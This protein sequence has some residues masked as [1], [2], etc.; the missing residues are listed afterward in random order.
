MRRRK[1][2]SPFRTVFLWTICLSLIGWGLWQAELLRRSV[3]SSSPP[4]ATSQPD[5]AIDSASIQR[6]PAPG[7]TPPEL[8]EAA[9]TDHAPT[10]TTQELAVEP[11]H[12]EP[13][14]IFD[15]GLSASDLYAQGHAAL[16]AGQTL[17]GRF[18]LNE[19]LA[20]T[21]DDAQAAELRQTLSALNLPIFLGSDLLPDDPAA[22]LVEIQDGDNFL[23]IARA[24]G[25]NAAFLQTLNPTLS[26]ANLKPGTG[27][28]IVQGPFQAR[29][30]KHADRLDLYARDLYVAS[31]AVDFPEG[32]DLP[33]GDYLIAPGTKLLLGPPAA[34]RIWLGFQGL[35]PATQSVT[36]GWIFGT[37]GPRG[38]DPRNR[39]TG[40]HL[41]TPDLLQLYN[42]LTEGRSHLHVDP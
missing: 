29:I 26:P 39:S 22:R 33:R 11:A 5:A 23:T 24:Y 20:R 40:I 38:T 42:T 3:I 12:L 17:A 31:C 1:R 14:P 41:A 30:S 6:P 9:A 27:I 7:D 4:P 36:S 21:T 18:A 25:I 2:S 10:I 15:P 8:I 32:N 37:A 13:L 19:A 34:G 28:K 35:E 16:A